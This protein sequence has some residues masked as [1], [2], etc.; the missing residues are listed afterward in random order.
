MFLEI[1]YF[2]A[3][4]FVR[5]FHRTKNLKLI[6]VHRSV[7]YVH[8]SFSYETVWSTFLLVF[9]NLVLFMMHRKSLL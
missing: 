1:R 8:N 6:L 7:Y 4:F 2:Y 5:K 9:Q 3:F